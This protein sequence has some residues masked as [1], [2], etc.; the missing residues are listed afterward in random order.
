MKKIRFLLLK[1]L[2]EIY[3]KSGGGALTVLLIHY[4]T[5]LMINK[6]ESEAQSYSLLVKFK[7]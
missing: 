1:L 7:L 2:I 6:L 4:I 5:V 3:R